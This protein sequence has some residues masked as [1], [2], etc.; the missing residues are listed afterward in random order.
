MPRDWT[1]RQ[2]LRCGGA[3]PAGVAGLELVG[4]VG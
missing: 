4:V 3:V 1:F 2:V